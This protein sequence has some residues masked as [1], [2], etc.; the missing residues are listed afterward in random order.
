MTNGERIG[1]YIMGREVLGR[2]L[3]NKYKT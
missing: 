1:I 3:K 2:E